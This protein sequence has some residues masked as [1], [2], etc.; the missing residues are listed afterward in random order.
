MYRHFVA[1]LEPDIIVICIN[2][3]NGATALAAREA[4][5]YD[6]VHFRRSR[7]GARSKLLARIEKNLVV[8]WRLS[9]AYS[10]RRK[11]TV[12]AEAVLRDSEGRFVDLVR[13]CQRGDRQ[14]VL[15]ENGRRLRP[16]QSPWQQLRAST[17]QVFYLP[18]LSIP[19]FLRIQQA[20]I[21]LLEQV[22][23]G[24]RCGFFDLSKVVPGDSRHYLDS[25]HFTDA[26]SRIFA[27]AMADGLHS[28]VKAWFVANPAADA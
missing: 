14:V 15:V 18:Y 25:A 13:N 11:L 12:D 24:T 8:L 6:G 4:G 19:G 3:I 2:D 1:P 23:A 28:R 27:D 9:Q 5:I 26:G 10:E 20:Q 16:D 21:E 22:A 7:L 17:S